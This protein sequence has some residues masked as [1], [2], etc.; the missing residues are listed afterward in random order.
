MEANRNRKAF[1]EWPTNHFPELGLHLA[2][3]LVLGMAAAH[4]KDMTV[5]AYI[6][7]AVLAMATSVT[8]GLPLAEVLRIAVAISVA[9]LV[10]GIVTLAW[11]ATTRSDSRSSAT[12]LHV[13]YADPDQDGGHVGN[14][15]SPGRKSSSVFDSAPWAPSK[16]RV[17]PGFR[18]GV[19]PLHA[20]W[21][22]LD[23]A[24]PAALANQT[25]SWRNPNPTTLEQLQSVRRRLAFR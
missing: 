2:L 13:K 19:A 25:D 3:L 20:D 9:A 8:T 11:V 22:M 16:P 4:V 15:P 12:S 17:R 23:D 21:A 1:S 7:G 18:P 5:E 24:L 6:V 10:L 14:W